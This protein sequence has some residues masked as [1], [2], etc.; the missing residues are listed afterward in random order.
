MN[1]DTLR[2]WEEAERKDG[3]LVDMLVWIFGSNI[4]YP[5]LMLRKRGFTVIP[6]DGYVP[7]D[8]VIPRCV[9]NAL[10]ERMK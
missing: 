9:Q 8:A 7:K 6:P 3:A 1:T 10:D 5:V 2:D 4:E